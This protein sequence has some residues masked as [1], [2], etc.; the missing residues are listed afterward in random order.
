MA[1]LDDPV[2]G[3]LWE[4]AFPRTDDGLKDR[5]FM[6]YSPDRNEVDRTHPKAD[7]RSKAGYRCRR[8]CARPLINRSSSVNPAD[9]G[10]AASAFFLVAVCHR[11]QSE[12]SA[13]PAWWASS[14]SLF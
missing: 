14:S 8:S 1:R 7:D 9:A 6:L 10:L 13:P 11:S 4:T 2:R 12:F 5:A 3:S